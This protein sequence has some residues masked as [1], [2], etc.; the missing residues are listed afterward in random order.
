MKVK[1]SSQLI[2]LSREQNSQMDAGTATGLF[3][4]VSVE[5]LRFVII[6]NPSIPSFHLLPSDSGISQYF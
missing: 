3:H 4:H 5:M 6:L 2:A 1:S